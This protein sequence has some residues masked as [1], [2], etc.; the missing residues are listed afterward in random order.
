MVPP[1]GLPPLYFA[2]QQQSEDCARILLS[3][4]S[5]KEGH[6]VVVRWLLEEWIREEGMWKAKFSW[7]MLNLLAIRSSLQF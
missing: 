2:V 3:N 7:N 6:G 1:S 5:A 4:I